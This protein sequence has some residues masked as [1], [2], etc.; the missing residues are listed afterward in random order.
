MGAVVLNQ[1]ESPSFPSQPLRAGAVCSGR[2]LATHP[3][4]QQVKDG[5][6]SGLIFLFF[7]DLFIYFWP[8]WVFIAVCR[9][10]AAVA[11]LAVENRL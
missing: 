4:G 8:C 6:G 10:L 2:L 5:P 9:H 11:S 3:R 1:R 7:Q